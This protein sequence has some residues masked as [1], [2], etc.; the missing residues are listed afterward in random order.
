MTARLMAWVLLGVEHFEQ[1]RRRV[2]GEVRAHL[3]YPV[4][5]ESGFDNF[6]LRI[7]WMILPGIEPI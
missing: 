4:Q 3:V 5:K 7:D 6:A 2:A 1:G